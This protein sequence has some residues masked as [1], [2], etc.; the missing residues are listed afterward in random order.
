[1]ALLKK[2]LD[3]K[4]WLILWNAIVIYEIF[5]NY[6]QTREDLMNGDSETILKARSFRLAQWLNIIRF[7]HETSKGSINLVVKFYPT[8]SSDMHCSR[9]EFGKETFW[10]RTFGELGTLD[11]SAI[12]ARRLNAKELISPK[13][14][15]FSY[16]QSQMVQ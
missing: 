13:V 3:E 7:L 10:L 15:K 1:M 12:H 8:Y 16:S 5:K 14:L 6:W 11:A 9:R 2:R 4:W